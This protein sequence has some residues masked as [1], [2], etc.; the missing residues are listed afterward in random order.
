MSTIE[1]KVVWRAVW[2]SRYLRGK[3]TSEWSGGV[4]KIYKHQGTRQIRVY[5]DSPLDGTQLK[6]NEM[7]PVTLRSRGRFGRLYIGF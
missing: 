7:Q 4:D 1:L 6:V 3:I 5:S 2:Y